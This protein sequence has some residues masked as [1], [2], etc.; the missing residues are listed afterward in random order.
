MA[1]ALPRTGVSPIQMSQVVPTLRV[2]PRTRLGMIPDYMSPP[3]KPFDPRM[4]PWWAQAIQVQIQRADLVA[5]DAFASFFF[6]AD[7]FYR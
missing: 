5:C 6:R 3:T 2:P 4:F 7:L 1:F